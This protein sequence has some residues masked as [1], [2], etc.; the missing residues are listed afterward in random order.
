M[1]E[2]KLDI[3]SLTQDGICMGE[4][5]MFFGISPFSFEKVKELVCSS[6]IDRITMIEMLILLIDSFEREAS[7]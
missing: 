7:Y 6:M 3:P 1:I 4:R 5:S 2:Y